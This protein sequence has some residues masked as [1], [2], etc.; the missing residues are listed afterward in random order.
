[1]KTKKPTQTELIRAIKQ[2]DKALEQIDKLCELVET[3]TGYPFYGIDAK[4][5]IANTLLYKDKNGNEFNQFDFW[6]NLHNF[7]DKNQDFLCRESKYLYNQLKQT[8]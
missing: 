5:T 6:D 4:N 2:N 3:I 7:C 1:M 8:K